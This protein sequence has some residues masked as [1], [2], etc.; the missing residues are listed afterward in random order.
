MST[1]VMD[2]EEKREWTREDTKREHKL[3]MCG[4]MEHQKIVKV[5]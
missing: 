4:W 3:A 2:T 1:V 5:A